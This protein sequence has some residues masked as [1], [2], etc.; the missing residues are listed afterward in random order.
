MYCSTRISRRARSA[1]I[2]SVLAVFLLAVLATLAVA[3]A[4]ITNLNARQSSNYRDSLAARLAAESGLS[5]MIMTMNTLRIP[6]TTTKETFLENSTTALAEKLDGTANL[7]ELSVTNMGTQVAI[8]GISIPQGTFSSSL[9]LVDPTH[10]RLETLGTVNGVSR[11]VRMDFQVVSR[12]PAVFDYGLASRGQ[13][14]VHGEAS[15]LGVNDPS[16]ASVLSTTL[17]H[18]DASQVS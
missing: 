15:I 1:G 2:A 6:G 18:D 13:I 4:T 16:E 3:L 11:R 10:C 5:Y 7:R 17:T 12:R 14:I 8:P 9:V